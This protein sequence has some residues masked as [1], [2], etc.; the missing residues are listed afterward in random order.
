MRQLSWALN[1]YD[2]EGD[3]YAEG[4]YLFIDDVYRLSGDTE[5]DNTYIH[6]IRNYN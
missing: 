6:L 4:L 1:L 3:K 5:N 2:N